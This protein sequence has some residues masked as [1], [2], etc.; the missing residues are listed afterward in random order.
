[1]STKV[2]RISQLTSR[3]RWCA[4]LSFNNRQGEHWL[5]MVIIPSFLSYW[6][7]QSILLIQ[8]SLTTVGQLIS[9]PVPCICVIVH[10]SFSHWINHILVLLFHVLDS[11][12]QQQMTR[13]QHAHKSF[14]L[15]LSYWDEGWA[16]VACWY[17]S[18]S[19]SLSTSCSCFYVLAVDCL[20]DLYTLLLQSVSPN[21]SC[22]SKHTA[23]SH[24]LL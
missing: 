20:L 4:L 8:S 7:K 16:I 2:C 3:S 9:S 14:E 22:N 11:P 23:I 21:V 5:S 19:P 12:L 1:M 24:V 13:H 17:V 15:T 6:F 10:Y 18:L